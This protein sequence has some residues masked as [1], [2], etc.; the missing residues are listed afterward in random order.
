MSMADCYFS[1]RMPVVEVI[2]FNRLSCAEL[3]ETRAGPYLE[4]LEASPR[5]MLI[6]TVY[7][8]RTAGSI[9]ATYIREPN[10]L[11]EPLGNSSGAADYF[12]EPAGGIITFTLFQVLACAGSG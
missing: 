2:R 5:D 11:S 9:W 6:C 10:P 1:A 8:V 4:P 12:W 7:C 3:K